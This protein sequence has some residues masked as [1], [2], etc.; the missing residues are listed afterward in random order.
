MKKLDFIIIGC[1][2]LIAGGLYF[3]GI[4][5]PGDYGGYAVV[6]VDGDKKAEY[7]LSEDSE[8]IINGIGG[9]NKL[10]IENGRAKM[11]EADC[12]DNV[13]VN[14]TPIYRENESIVCLPHKVVVEIEGGEKGSINF[15]AG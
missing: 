10:V 2:V 8:N 1:V 14:H 6:Y 3:S 12:P 9:V 4:L 11:T 7:S 15:I 5:S 13:C